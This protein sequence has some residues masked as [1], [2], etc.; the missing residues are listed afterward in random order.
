MPHI[1]N[2]LL[3]ILYDLARQ[4]VE[5]IVTCTVNFDTHELQQVN[6]NIQ[7]QMKCQLFGTSS[8][9]NN[10][11]ILLYTYQPQFIAPESLAPLINLVFDEVLP[12]SQLKQDA[13]KDEIYG[14]L[15]LSN[16]FMAPQQ[17]EKRTN[18]VENR[19]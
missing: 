15:T 12:L 6:T 19:L 7:Y 4:Q 2:R 8:G 11:D 13:S 5:C 10:W 9:S 17:L 14:L 18:L 16:A 1:M 3:E